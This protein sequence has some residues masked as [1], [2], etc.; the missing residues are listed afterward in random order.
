M[1]YKNIKSE[2][3]DPENPFAPVCVGFYE[4]RIVVGGRERRVMIYIPED[5][6]PSTAGIVLV[7]PSGM[8]ID[9]FLEISNWIEIADTEETKEKLVLMIVE[10][11][12]DGWNESERY[13]E[14]DGDVAYIYQAYQ[15]FSLRT[16]VCVHE[17]KKY[18]VGY[19]QGGTMAQM[20][21][22]WDPAAFSGM[23]SIDGP[24][25]EK[26]YLEQAEKDFAV[27]LYGYEDPDHIKE[28]C[29][30]KIPL[31]AWFIGNKTDADSAAVTYFRNACGCENQ[32]RMI[33]TQTRGY[34]RIKETEYPLNQDK[35]AYHVWVSDIQDASENMGRKINRRIW[36][37][38]LYPVRRW[39]GD[40]AG[41][42]RITED[43]VKDLGMEYHY[44]TIGEY[45]REWYVYV[46]ETV[47]A[48]PQTEVPLV[49]AM[50][51]YS[52]SGEIYIG[53][54]G[55]NRVADEYG[56]I[57]IYPT[58][59]PGYIN[60]TAAEGGVSP[61]NIAL[62]TWNCVGYQEGRPYELDFFMHMLE[63]VCR[64]YNIDQSRIYITGHSNGSMITQ[65]LALS[66]PELFAA[67]APCS[68]ILYMVGCEEA[69]DTPEVKA[70]KQVDLPIWMMGGEREPWLLEAFP[71]PK[72]RTGKSISAWWNLNQMPGE[73]PADYACCRV[74]NGRWDEW[75][76]DKERVPMIRFSS[77]DY[78]PHAT[79]PEQSFRIWEDFF[80]KYRR[81]QDGQVIF[82]G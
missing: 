44:E 14:A 30:G 9:E 29:K 20:T 48:C 4:N 59:V 54:S 33:D 45:K 37:S 69:L 68:G 70:R 28:I 76:F 52:C 16:T 1:E 67:A 46:P 79:M 23:V 71:E 5:I 80:C 57:V 43:P 82:E 58:A 31:P 50:H 55:W 2:R 18:L 60:A 13:G 36:K 47:K 38:F 41:S 22:V 12:P 35:E 53:N 40:P 73:P 15:L 24:N 81:G 10:S 78:F 56:F 3:V 34:D 21:A 6:R 32:A 66:K 39:M 19:Q 77:I 11:G 25:V 49:F 42:L 8:S 63:D 61:D 75:S 65:W 17:A 7:P 51:G 62:P 64:G 27:N 74:R 72:N 26:K